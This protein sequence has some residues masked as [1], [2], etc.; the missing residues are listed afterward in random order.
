MNNLKL[1]LK[2][3]LNGGTVDFKLT[4]PN[5][6]LIFLYILMGMQFVSLVITLP[7]KFWPPAFHVLIPL[8]FLGGGITALFLVLLTLN[9]SWKSVKEHLMNP[10]SIA[11]ILLSIMLYLLLLPFTELFS[12]LVPIEGNDFLRNLYEA[13]KANFEMLL[14][15]KVAGFITVCILAPVIEEILFRGL[16]LRG[17]LQNGI[18]PVVSIVLSAVL[19]GAA[20]LNPWQ[21][22]GAG[23][24]GAIFGFVYYR[25]RSLWLCVFL[26]GL[27]NLI[28]FVFMMKEGSLE[29][30]VTDTENF[31]SISVFFFLA[32]ICGWLI[33][34]LTQNKPKWN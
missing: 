6:F 26:H 14:D 4:V 21:F 12:S 1:T 8:G 20:H 7:A 27:N 10:T 28:A 17:L 33:Y 22:M 9:A 15:Y 32:L 2:E 18:S 23:F 30:N 34:K 24:L 5:S 19:F 31:I 11:L 3:I 29:G 16:L 25:T 13:F